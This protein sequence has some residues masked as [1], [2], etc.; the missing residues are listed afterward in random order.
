MPS[1]VVAGNGKQ[2]LSDKTG[3]QHHTTFKFVEIIIWPCS[4]ST[5]EHGGSF[6]GVILAWSNSTEA[7]LSVEDLCEQFVMCKA[8]CVNDL[9]LKVVGAN[10]V[11]FFCDIQEQKKTEI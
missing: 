6:K 10:S 7:L 8:M 11:T 1:T 2:Q 9:S 5:E 4:S 3:T